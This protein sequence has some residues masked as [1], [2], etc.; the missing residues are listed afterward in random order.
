MDFVYD[1]FM[2]VYTHTVAL[3]NRKEIIIIKTQILT[4]Y[5]YKISVINFN[6]TAKMYLLQ[7]SNNNNNNN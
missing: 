7:I 1:V 4:N 6:Y 2:C 3:E 5:F